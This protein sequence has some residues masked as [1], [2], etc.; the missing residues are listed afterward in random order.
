MTGWYGDGS[1]GDEEEGDIFG[2]KEEEEGEEVVA[3]EVGE[4]EANGDENVVGEEEEEEEADNESDWEDYID[5]FPELER[6]GIRG[7][8]NEAELE[9]YHRT[10]HRI[11]RRNVNPTDLDD[12][13]G[14]TFSP[15]PTPNNSVESRNPRASTASS[16]TLRPRSQI[17]FISYN[18][19]PRRSI[20]AA[21]PTPNNSVENEGRNPRVSIASSLTLRTRPMSFISHHAPPPPHT[22]SART[23]T[24]LPHRTR[25]ISQI[26]SISHH[27]PQTDH[28]PQSSLPPHQRQR[29]KIAWRSKIAKKTTSVR[30]VAVGVW[31]GVRMVG[32][33]GM[34]GWWSRRGEEW[35][36][37][38][39]S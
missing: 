34:S 3:E 12:P 30:N 28:L 24:Q 16:L 33:V 10:C 15:P 38:W 1:S 26:S 22:P 27:P 4:E 5:D 29:K 8:A 11:H 39:F 31:V 32:G 19:S 25:R 7:V 6:Q 35:R 20:Y 36:G 37:R 14:Q 2:E 9:R 17:S 21:P 23:S 13:R 18:P